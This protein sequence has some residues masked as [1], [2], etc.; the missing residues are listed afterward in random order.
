MK[1]RI[2]A[3]S[4]LLGGVTVAAL[5]QAKPQAQ[6]EEY[7]RLVKE[8]TTQPEFMSPL[9]DHLPKATGV[10]TPKDVL[11][12]YAGAPKKLTRVADL[13]RYYRALAAASKRVKI[14]P[15]GTTDEGREC[16]VAAISDEETIRD[17]D[18]Y[19][20][21]LAKLA[22]P[23]G[24]SAVEA[25]RIIALAKPIYMLTGGL[26][27]AETGPPEMLMELAYRLAVDESPL[28]EQI[29]HN[30]IVM[31]INAAEPDGR[32]RYVD[33]YYRYKISEETEEDRQPGPPYWG[34]Y[35]FHD[36]NRDINYSQVTMR[37]W[38]KFYLQWHPPIMH[39]LHESEPFMYTF[40][41]QAP[42]NPTL[43][44]ILYGELPWFSNFEMTRMISLG[45]PGVWTHAF[46]D[47][48][49]PGYL[50]FM[51]SNH[52]GML[53]MYE[54]FG[55]GGA[56]TMKRT[57]DAPP[58]AGGGAEGGGGSMTTREWYRPLPPYKEVVWSMRN[59]TNYMETGVLSALELTAGFA[60]TVLENFYDKSRNS[61]DAGNKQAPFGY[62]IPAGQKDMTRVA[63][64]VN[65]LRIQGVEVGR[66]TQE[67]KL[68][69]GA[70]PAGS[71]VVKCNQPYGRLAK[72]LLEK[73]Q[74]PDPSLRTYDDTGWTM[75]LMSQAEVVETADAAVL[76]AR[77]QPVDQLETVG[78]VKGAGPWTVV[79]HNGAN[80]LAELRYRLKDLTYD[81]LAQPIKSEGLELPAGSLLI[82]SSARVTAEIQKMGLQAVALS[83]APNGQKR[84]ADPPRLAV[85][86]TWGSTQDVGWVRYALDHFEFVYDLI[87]KERVRKGNLRDAYEVIVIPSQGRSS[88]SLVFDIESKGVALAYNKTPEF[89]TLGMYGESA[90][91]TG[92]MGLEGVMELEKFVRAG[93]VLITLGAASFFPADYG[94][95]RTVDA[96]RPSA[97]FYA[98]GPVVEAVIE[99]P[100]HPIFYGYTEK[101]VPVRY[102]NGPLLRVPTEDQA[103]WVLMQYTGTDRS[104]LSGFMRGVAETRGK[105][106]ILDVPVGRGRVI[107]F[108]TNP[109]YRWQNLGEFNMLAN[110]ILYYNQLP[111]SRAGA[112]Q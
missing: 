29:R 79:L 40:S 51:S 90:D 97:Q 60:K 58:G 2:F 16:L 80:S 18:T 39:D 33:W 101:T 1:L 12:Y 81:A 104:V 70:F 75:G 54:T 43:D 91:I 36:N 105:P 61:I 6:D 82:P 11:G 46:V 56:N 85:Y 68:K 44:P 10:P 109:C 65:I 8:W 25:K 13:S 89:P 88:K 31:V 63:F 59:N 15:A 95:T 38:L 26:H 17:L 69:E 72:I 66:A 30:T 55:N 74:Y 84:P 50:G 112:A 48:W 67:I 111:R 53:R 98:P 110:A 86:S 45:M 47:M 108:A 7:A 107:L 49:S 41:G 3:L 19:K 103:K 64:I 34:K 9:V 77:V 24:L 14:L 93:G 35:I 37:N 92:G 27:S 62:V 99:Q 52:N 83:Q 42:Q 87:Y 57:V 73:Q 106:A 96:A 94:I 100:T 23:R 5:A 20:G 76:D 4:L 21:Y 22:D 78:A 102:A 71:L 28:Y 32:D